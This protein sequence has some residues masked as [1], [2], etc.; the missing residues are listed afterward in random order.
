MQ[1]KSNICIVFYCYSNKILPLVSTEY[2]LLVTNEI[3]VNGVLLN[4]ILTES[5][6]LSFECLVIMPFLFQLEFH[7]NEKYFF[8]TN[9]I[10]IKFIGVA[11]LSLH[12]RLV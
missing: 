9:V 3:N 11:V 4:I 7:P 12:Y 2:Q 5:L 6:S 8:L 1:S 10:S